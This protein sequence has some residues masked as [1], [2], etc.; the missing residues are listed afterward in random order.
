MSDEIK[1]LDQLIEIGND[2]APQE[3]LDN[4]TGEGVGGGL[5]GIEGGKI[6]EILADLPALERAIQADYET[7]F[8]GCN[9]ENY[10]KGRGGNK[11]THIVVHYTA[12]AQTAEGAARA[13]CIYFGRERVGASAH[14][15]VDDGYTI[16]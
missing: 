8:H 6:A 2:G 7:S 5:E 14:Y 13:N 3:W 1:T 9:H 10:T 4:L 15:F 11:V 16:W 12:G